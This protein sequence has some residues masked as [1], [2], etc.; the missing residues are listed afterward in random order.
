MTSQEVGISSPS[1][2]K[3]YRFYEAGYFFHRQIN[4]QFLVYNIF[5]ELT[6]PD[7][8]ETETHGWY[9]VNCNR[10]PRTMYSCVP[11]RS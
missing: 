10:K 9:H 1:Q 8:H 5:N 7:V 4:L 3:N 2:T 11:R 6:Y